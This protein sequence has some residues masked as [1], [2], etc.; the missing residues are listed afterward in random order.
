[1]A[2]TFN[3]NDQVYVKDGKMGIGASDPLRK[4]HV[5]GNFSVNASTSQYYG[6]L[7]NGGES[8]NPAITIGDW[9]NSS[10][11]I[12]W[13]ST[14]NYLV[15]DSQHSSSGS[16]ILFT[17][18]DSAT[19][20]MRIT[21]SGNV[22][23]GTTSP[24]T[25][26]ELAKTTT[27]G[28]LSNQVIYINNNGTGGN[29]NDLHDMGSI[30]WRSGNVNTAA[31]SA[32]R[33]TPGSGNNVELRFTTATQAS[34]QQTSM[35]ITSGGN[36]GIGTT[37]PDA[38]LTIDGDGNTNNYQGVLRIGNTDTYKWSHISMPD[39]LSGNSESN[40][41]Y[42]IGRGASMSD[43]IMSFHIPNNGDYGDAVQPK[44]QFYSTGTDLLHSIEAETGKSFFK[45][46]LGV[47]TDDPNSTVDI[48]GTAM[49]QL[50]LRTAGGP[51]NNVDTNGREGDFAYD[52]Q[53]LY[54]KTGNGWGRVA[55][56]FAF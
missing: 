21:G 39:T 31:I 1:M 19:E 11:T 45:G 42:L 26:L 47:R 24:G 2:I 49:Q 10:S 55:L 8:S 52:D 9:H 6:V 32:I 37:S 51:S 36:V 5:V 23:I 53:Y 34:G 15:I 27:W 17:G 12:K 3:H 38:K 16:A 13:D 56:D 48:N 50:R 40:N 41:Y 18:N 29:I 46:D 30:T 25:Q 43:R 14:N 22:G 28:T 44:F 20:Y 35:T 4:L 7:I 33:N 54:I